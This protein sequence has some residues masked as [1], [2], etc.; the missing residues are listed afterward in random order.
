M[1]KITTVS[2]S[3][4]SETVT[5]IGQFTGE[6]LPAVRSILEEARERGCSASLDLWNVTFVDREAMGFLCSQKA[7]GVVVSRCPSYVARWVKQEQ[8]DVDPC[9]SADS[10]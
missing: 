1:L 3:P 2:D 10:Q 4:E 5:L 8:G 6:Y 9:S 7:Q